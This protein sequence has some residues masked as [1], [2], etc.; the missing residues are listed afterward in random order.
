MPRKSKYPR[1]RTHTR[2][3]KGGQVWTSWW[4]DMRPD[5]K[6]DISLGTDYEQA[7][8]LWDELA[9]QKPRIIG[10][11][12]EAFDAW[13]KEVLPEYKSLETR[14]GYT[15][16]LRHLRPVFNTATWDAVDFPTLKGYLK[17]RTAKVQGNREMALFSII[18]RWAYGEGYTT[19]P[20]PAAGMERSK[21][22][23]KEEART[24]EVSDALF[25]AVYSQASPMLRAA[26]DIATATGLR[27]TDVR[28]VLVPTNGLLHVKASKTGKAATFEVALSPV[29]QTTVAGRNQIAANHLMLLSTPS[30]RPVSARMLREAFETAR[31]SAA[32]AHPELADDLRKMYLR[33]MR[34]RAADLAGDLKEASELLQHSSTK[35]TADHYRTK[36]TKVRPV[37]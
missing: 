16:N 24:F 7:L 12:Q 11:I 13:E 23:N 15:Q 8:K 2:K 1:L 20:W 6:P 21:W 19:L 26:M 4:F 30:G 10:T 33:D 17:K 3:G 29:L 9:N 35:V 18:W 32:E 14:K 27:L 36:P 37:R 28:T 31:E 5:G 25:A 22:K 34:K